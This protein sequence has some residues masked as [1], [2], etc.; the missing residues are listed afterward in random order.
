MLAVY[1]KKLLS[2]KL[3]ELAHYTVVIFEEI[4]VSE[5]Q[6]N[7]SLIRTSFKITCNV[8]NY[9]YSFYNMNYIIN[10]GIYSPAKYTIF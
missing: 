2:V 7:M 6:L 8:M 1:K 9:S 5:K 3:L 10:V 4:V